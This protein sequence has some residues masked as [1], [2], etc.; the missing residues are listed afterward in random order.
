MIM[1]SPKW[2]QI[3]ENVTKMS[4][5]VNDNEATVLISSNSEDSEGT[6]SMEDVAMPGPSTSDIPP[7]PCKRARKNVLNPDLAAALDLQK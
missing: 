1:M 5:I 6:F 7:A 3:L 2:R 4:S